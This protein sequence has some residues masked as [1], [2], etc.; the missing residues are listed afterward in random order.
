MHKHLWKIIIGL[1]LCISIGFN[2]HTYIQK[3]SHDAASDEDTK[4]IVAIQTFLTSI[5]PDFIKDEQ[6]IAN[7]EHI[8]SWG[9]GPS[10]YTLGKILNTKFFEGKLDI[11]PTYDNQ[12]YE[13]LE[14]FGFVEYESKGSR[15]VGD[16]AW[17]EIYFHDRILFIDPTV[18]Q[19]GKVQSIATEIFHVGDPNISTSLRQSYNIIDD[20]VSTLVQ[21]VEHNIPINDVPY[22]G[23]YISKEELPYYKRVVELR[24]LVSL[25]KEPAEWEP[26][27]TYLF[28]KY[29]LL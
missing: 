2:L 9:C 6:T 15:I 13:I 7:Q 21:K 5:A 12:P 11:D 29:L 20:R 18:A 23:L 3:A 8:P 17:L 22:P 14:R 19:Y 10:S 28:K 16:H 26:W 1:A 25:H 27:T 24:T 4:K